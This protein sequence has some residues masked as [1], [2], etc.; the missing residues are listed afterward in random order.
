M[1]LNVKAR[2]GRRWNEYSQSHQRQLKR[3]R[4]QQYQDSLLWLEKQGYRLLSVE[5]RNTSTGKVEKIELGHDELDELF[6]SEKEQI[7]EEDI[8]VLNMMLLIK[9]QYNVSTTAYHEMS[10]V[11]KSLPRSYKLKQRIKELNSRWDI[12]LTPYGTVGFQQSLE[13]RLRIRVQH[14]LKSSEPDAGLHNDGV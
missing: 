13:D 6:G 3:D 2:P 5:V 8:D 12:R 10:E 11:C 14:L 4:L 9:D 1:E 7:T